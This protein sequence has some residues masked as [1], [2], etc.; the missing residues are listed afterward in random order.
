MEFDVFC[1]RGDFT[2]FSLHSLSHA[3]VNPMTR[4][5]PCLFPL[6]V[7]PTIIFSSSPHQAHPRLSPIQPSC[8]LANSTPLI[9]RILGKQKQGLRPIAGYQALDMKLIPHTSH[10][11]IEQLS[12]AL[13]AEHQHRASSELQGH[14]PP[15]TP[16]TYCRSCGH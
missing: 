7:T 16:P 10:G 1:Q 13:G 15:A 12:Q 14:Q 4:K 2:R 9:L 5:P 3:L 8:A 6:A 11:G